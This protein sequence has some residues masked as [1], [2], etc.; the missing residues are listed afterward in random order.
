MAYI[1]KK[2]KTGYKIMALEINKNC[3]KI[4]KDKNI[5]S[6]STFDKVR[7]QLIVLFH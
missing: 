6:F 2:L 7:D 5:N 3:L 4:L 1:Q